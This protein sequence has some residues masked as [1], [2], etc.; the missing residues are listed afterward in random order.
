VRKFLA[1]IVILSSVLANAHAKTIQVEFLQAA[2]SPQN[3][4]ALSGLACRNLDRIVHLDI[5]VEWPT[6]KTHPE[7]DDYKRLVFWD[8]ETE[9]LFPNGSYFFLHGSWIIKGYFIARSGG[10]HQG[11]SSDSFEK[12][13]DASVMLNPNVTETKV[14]RSCR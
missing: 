6:D 8:D 3:V 13:D 9:Y 10:M 5:A 14:F 4:G 1:I 2:I 11:V 12:I 7:I